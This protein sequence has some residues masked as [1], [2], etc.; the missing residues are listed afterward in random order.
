MTFS[1]T[2]YGRIVSCW[3]PFRGRRRRRRADEPCFLR[4]VLA[5]VFLLGLVVVL[6]WHLIAGKRAATKE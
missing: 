1:D 4:S 3:M 6:S 2:D 5:G